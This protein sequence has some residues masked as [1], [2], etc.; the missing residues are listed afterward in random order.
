MAATAYDMFLFE[1]DVLPFASDV[2]PLANHMFLLGNCML[3][4]ENDMLMFENM[5]LL[6]NDM[7]LFESECFC[8]KICFFLKMTYSIRFA[9]PAS[10]SEGKFLYAYVEEGGQTKE[11][12]ENMKTRNGHNSTCKPRV[13]V[14]RPSNESS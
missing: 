10:P 14:I 4:F 2:F 3:L 5:F 1:N 12:L 11:K 9:I 8:S 6:E 7:F 13:Y